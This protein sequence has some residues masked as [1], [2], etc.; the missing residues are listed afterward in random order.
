MQNIENINYASDSGAEAIK[1]LDR[2]QRKIKEHL[3]TINVDGMQQQINNLND[4]PN[5]DTINVTDANE[6]PCG[7]YSGNL[8]NSP[9]GDWFTYH[10]FYKLGSGYKT[11]IAYGINNNLIYV[12]IYLGNMWGNWEVVSGRVDVGITLVNGWQPETTG[13]WINEA[14]IV[15]DTLFFNAAVTNPSGVDPWSTILNFNLGGRVFRNNI[16]H[17][18]GI[19]F[20]N[21]LT[22][23]VYTNAG[24]YSLATTMP[25]NANTLYHI[26]GHARLY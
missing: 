22:F 4:V 13:A 9:V 21:A 25:L 12:R 1:K 3:D 18:C 24:G 2:N 15:G 8:S 19:D 26:T 6:L 7:W 11:Q 14:W 23:G 10:T 20:A 16:P 5:A 17:P